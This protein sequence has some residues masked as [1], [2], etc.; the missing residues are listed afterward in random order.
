MTLCQFGFSQN[1]APSC[2]LKYQDNFQGDILINTLRVQSPSPTCTYYCA[3]Q[4]NAGGEGGGYCGIQEHPDGRNFIFSIWDPISSTDPITASYSHTG[5]VVEPFGGEG[6]GLK[7]WNFDIGWSTDQWYSFVTRAW[8]DNG[9]TMFGYWVFNYTS[10]EWYHLVIMDYPVPNVRF[11][12]T[13]GSF[14]EDW[15]GNGS[16]TREIHHKEGWKRK[17]S[18]LSW[19]PFTSSYF[20]RVNPDPGAANFINN[21]DGGIVT[22][23]YFMKSGGSVSPV[24]NTS[25]A[26]LFL[27]NS[28]SDHGFPTGEILGLNT[29][30]STNLLTLDWDINVSKSPQFS[31]HVEIYDNASF[32]GTPLVQLDQNVPHARTSD[33][34]ISSLISSTEYY[35]RFYMIDIFDNQSTP[36]TDSFTAEISGINNMDNQITFNYYPNPFQG[37]MYLNFYK[38]NETYSIKLTNIL[39][40]TIFSNEYY[41][42]SVIEIYFPNNLNKGVYFLSITNQ[43]GKSRTIKL[44]KD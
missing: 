36:V 3:L 24:T 37:K 25:G 11:N 6:T 18:D 34:D 10:Q 12:S 21:Y 8:D 32:S 44:I 29:T 27:S 23:Y 5:T 43:E 31:Y 14:I 26:T 13:T 19:N 15:L 1:R 38:K 33:I 9:H 39:G 28:N 41:T 16:N 20:E 22:D 42:N 35:I 4:W 30:I 7:S 2:W 17:T 40:S